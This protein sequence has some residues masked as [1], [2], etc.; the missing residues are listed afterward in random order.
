MKKTAMTVFLCICF[1]LCL[2]PAVWMAVSPSMERIGNERVVNLPAWKDEEEHW[3]LNLLSQLG[4]YF[5]Q[6]Y[7][8]RPQLITADAALQTSLFQVSNTDSVITGKDGWLFYRSTLEDYLGKNV[9]SERGIYNLAHNLSLLQQYVRS[10][11]AEFLFLVPPNKNTL[12]PE[13]MPY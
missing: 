9:L 1:A 8:F 11:N 6:H 7:A 2:V 12:Y 4:D 5:E 3:N 13:Y 10:Q